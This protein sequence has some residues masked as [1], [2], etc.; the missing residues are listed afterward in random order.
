MKLFASLLLA[1]QASEFSDIIT[2]VNNANAGWVAGENF[3][4][5]TT[6]G[7]VKKWLGRWN[8]KDYDAERPYPN[9][10]AFGDDPVPAEFDARTNWPK[11]IIIMEQFVILF[12]IYLSNWNRN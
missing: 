2:E 3:H 5:S 8:N 12:I 6:L 9:Y 10:D 4:S 11:V 1:V 7:D